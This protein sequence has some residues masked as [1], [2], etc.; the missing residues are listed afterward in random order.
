MIKTI[1]IDIKINWF[2][3]GE[4]FILETEDAGIDTSLVLYKN[5]GQIMHVQTA[6]KKSSSCQIEMN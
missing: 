1:P 3:Y 4:W 6:P 5:L 2:Y